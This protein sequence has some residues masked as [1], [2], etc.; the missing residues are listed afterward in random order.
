MRLRRYSMEQIQARTQRN[1]TMELFKLLASAL[2]VFI[3]TPFPGEL[4]GCLLAWAALR[5]LTFS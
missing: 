5:S 1:Q 4:G 2:V 3:H